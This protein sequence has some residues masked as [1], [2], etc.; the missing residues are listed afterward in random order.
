MN[1]RT[2]VTP[3]VAAALLG[4]AIIAPAQNTPAYRHRQET[5]NQW[6]NAAYASGALGL[7]GLLTHKD[8]ITA[9]GAAGAGYSLYRYEHDR[10]SQRALR[11]RYYSQRYYSHYGL[12]RHHRLHR[13]VRHGRVYYW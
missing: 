1:L 9:I 6:R 7:L 11:D 5:K 8:T 4:S 2:L 3:I 12:K 10:K 13:H